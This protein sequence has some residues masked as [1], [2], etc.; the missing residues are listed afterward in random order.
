MFQSAFYLKMIEETANRLI[1]TGLMNY[2]IKTIL[3][4]NIK[5]KNPEDPPKVLSLTDLSFGFNIWIGFCCLCISS[6]ILEHLL[7]K[8]YIKWNY[9]SSGKHIKY[10]KIW[11]LKNFQKT[12]TIKL[13]LQT[14]NHFRIRKT[15]ECKF[16]DNSLKTGPGNDLN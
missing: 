16:E 5:I 11:S 10:A 15:S 1:D 2:L 12:Q 9:Y 6:F 8:L 3:S 7:V 14:Q 13:K 4:D